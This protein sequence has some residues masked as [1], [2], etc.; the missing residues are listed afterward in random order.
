M[1]AA[2]KTKP[3]APPPL[4]AERHRITA[5]ALQRLCC[6]LRRTSGE[7]VAGRPG[8][9]QVGGRLV[10]FVGGLPA[11]PLRPPALQWRDAWGQGEGNTDGLGWR[12]GR[13]GLW[14]REE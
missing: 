1:Q 8:Q 14:Q 4:L 5:P 3:P 6:D 10:L 12:E 7:L 9:Q 13:T 2:A 11:V